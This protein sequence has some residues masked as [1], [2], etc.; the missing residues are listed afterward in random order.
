MPS[1]AA[2][3]STA[4]TPTYTPRSR[5]EVSGR[6]TIRAPS[7]TSPSPTATRTGVG[8]L[9]A[10]QGGRSSGAHGHPF[11]PR[12]GRELPADRAIIFIAIPS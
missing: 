7:S 11:N 3:E 5:I 12:H 8:A 10:G 2:P 1:S 4:L 9:R 6:V